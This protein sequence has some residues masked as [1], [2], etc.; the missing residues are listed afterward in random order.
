METRK[1][2]GIVISAFPGCG[3]TWL[4]NKLKDNPTG[5]LKDITATDSDSSSYS[6]VVV[7]GV[8]QRNPEFPSN[9]IAHIRE[10]REQYDFVFV[11]THQEVRDAMDAEGIPFEL[12]YPDPKR[13][14]EWVG[15]YYLRGNTKEFIDKI[16]SH[17]DEWITDIDVPK[18]HEIPHIR[19]KLTDG[20]FLSNLI[21]TILLDTK[22]RKE[23]GF[24]LRETEM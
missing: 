11:S 16:V 22:A 15:N 17:W 12:V 6:W 8:K 5:I 19:H 3:K 9:Y 21:T 24:E 18:E 4:V 23:N 7:D 14:A 10:A 2:H 13:K 20:Y 1:K